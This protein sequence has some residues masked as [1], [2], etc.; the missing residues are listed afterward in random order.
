MKYYHGENYWIDRND[1]KM[2]KKVRAK[3]KKT[4][5]RFH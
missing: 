2:D 3:D 5:R 1:P 4:I